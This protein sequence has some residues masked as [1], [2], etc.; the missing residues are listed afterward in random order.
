MFRNVS[1]F[2][3][4][5]LICIFLVKMDPQNLSPNH[6]KSTKLQ[7]V[8]ILWC[9]WDAPF[10]EGGFWEVLGG[11]LGGFLDLRS[12]KLTL[13]LRCDPKVDSYFSCNRWTQLECKVLRTKER[14]KNLVGGSLIRATKKSI[15]GEALIRIIIR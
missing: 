15:H 2:V 1:F 13:I 12:E 9:V 7:K 5:S 6:P 14:W 8:T 4:G 10:V 3:P 11:I